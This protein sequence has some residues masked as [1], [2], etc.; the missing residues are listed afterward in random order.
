MSGTF[1]FCEN[2]IRNKILLRHSGPDF[3]FEPK[4]FTGRDNFKNSCLPNFWSHL[5]GANFEKTFKP[6]SNYLR[7]P[8]QNSPK[9]N[10]FCHVKSR[11]QSPEKIWC[12]II[13][14]GL[15]F[16]K[17]WGLEDIWKS[18]SNLTCYFWW[19]IHQ[20]LQNFIVL[21]RNPLQIVSFTESFF[22]ICSYYV[23]LKNS[24]AKSFW[25]WVTSH[26]KIESTSPNLVINKFSAC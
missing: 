11:I 17:F 24:A 21:L 23:T 7:I 4:D 10:G 1:F 8:L 15:V 5:I 13:V 2:R 25:S 16:S 26:S 12:F 9:Y 3:F 22:K 20:I 18:L 6:L 19:K 14:G